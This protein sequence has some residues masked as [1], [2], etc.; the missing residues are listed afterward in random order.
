MGSLD[1]TS[2]A[3]L[4]DATLLCIS[5]AL[6]ALTDDRLEVD[7]QDGILTIVLE[8]GG[9]YLINR[10]AP[11]RQIWMSS[12]VSGAIHFDWSGKQNGWV[13]TRGEGGL[14]EILERELSQATG[15][16]ILLA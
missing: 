6:E 2:F 9:H 5:D 1:E 7:L 11:N 16:S 15:L 4:A 8:T 14:Q 13:G 12:P 10:H 3:K